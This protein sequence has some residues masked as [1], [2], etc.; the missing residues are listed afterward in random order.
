MLTIGD[1]CGLR[2]GAEICC[3]MDTRVGV[4]GLTFVVGVRVEFGGADPIGGLVEW[5]DR[6]IFDCC[7][8]GGRRR[9]NS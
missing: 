9:L 4:T 6:V 7:G 3:C 5:L 8:G 1:G 2:L